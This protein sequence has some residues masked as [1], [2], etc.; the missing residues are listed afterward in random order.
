MRCC[1]NYF[2]SIPFFCGRWWRTDESTMEIHCVCFYCSSLRNLHMRKIN[3]VRKKLKHM[4]AALLSVL[5]CSRNEKE[6]RSK[7]KIF[8]Y[9]NNAR[10][11]IKWNS[12]SKLCQTGV[13]FCS[14]LI[15]SLTF[16]YW[17]WKYIKKWREFFPRVI[18]FSKLPAFY[19][20]L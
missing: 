2:S 5:P 19:S 17:F 10:A 11:N 8:I 9:L 14:R 18:T 3:K 13:F 4:C 6:K 20:N 16:K 7:C 1:C 15:L 12:E